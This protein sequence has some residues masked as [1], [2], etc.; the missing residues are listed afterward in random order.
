MKV[1]GWVLLSRD[2]DG[3]RMGPWHIAWHEVF[4]TKTNAIRF[5]RESAWTAPVKAVRGFLSTLT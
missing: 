1:K 5:A 4:C 2:V 3:S